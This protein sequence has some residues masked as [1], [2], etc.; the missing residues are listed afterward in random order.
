L[1][2]HGT[3]TVRVTELKKG[4]EKIPPVNDYVFDIGL[5]RDEERCIVFRAPVMLKRVICGSHSIGTRAHP[6]RWLTGWPTVSCG[7]IWKPPK[8]FQL[9][10]EVSKKVAPTSLSRQKPIL[11]NIGERVSHSFPSNGDPPVE[12]HL[13]TTQRSATQRKRY[14]H[15]DPTKHILLLFVLY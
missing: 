10:L 5:E 14:S 1:L 2:R 12:K 7:Q 15:G 3:G 9:R 4:V 8:V 6:R 11:A 13:H